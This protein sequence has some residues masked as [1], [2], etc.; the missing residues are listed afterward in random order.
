MVLKL[1]LP[2][3]KYKK[4]YYDMVDEAIKNNDIH[5][6]GNAYKNGETF[7]EM[8]QRLKDRRNGI[9]IVSREV[10]ATIYWMIVDNKVVGTIDLRHKLNKDYYERL[11]NVAYYVKKSSRNNGFATEALKQ[12]IKIYQKHNIKKILITCFE[13]NIASINVIKKNNGKLECKFKDEMTNKTILK[14][15]ISISCDTCPSIAW[16]TTNRTC[17]NSCQWCYASNC[18][19]KLDN[20]DFEKLKSTVDELKKNDIKRIIIIGGEPT[21]NKDINKIISYISAKDIEVSMAS[22]GRKFSDDNFAKELV[23]N[24][25][26]VCNISIKGANEKEY[27][28]NTKSYGFHEMV[29]GYHNLKKL[30]VKVSLSYVLCDMDLANFDRFLDSFL[31]NKL[32]NIVFQLYKPSVDENDDF[33]TPDINDL[34]QLCKYVYYKLKKTSIKF[35]F[36][37]SIPLCCL[38]EKLLNDMLKD[39]VI[40]TCCHIS[41]GKGI[42]FDTNFDILPCNHFVDHPLNSVKI[43]PTK[44]IDFW[45]SDTCTKF[46]KIVHTY[47]SQKCAKCSLW[48]ICGG[49]CF[50]RWLKYDPDKY[51]NDRYFLNGGEKN[52]G[53]RVSSK[54]ISRN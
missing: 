27:L 48:K 41:K 33:D 8:L 13:D 30:G 6:M 5:E 2:C 32:D 29:K 43:P 26:S 37:I 50:L 4:S 1:I 47:P 42:V 20:M 21:I 31:E 51:I 7:E 46:R 54:K 12:A 9:N 24:G 16:L 14:W 18:K 45:N 40:T 19:N 35:S 36:E 34:A 44:I 15:W 49:G 25:L 28:A 11:G 10:P 53:F 17:N 22:N 39:K 38:D 3:R 23:D 52:D